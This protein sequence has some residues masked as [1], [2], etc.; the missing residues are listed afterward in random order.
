MLKLPLLVIAAAHLDACNGHS[1][2]GLGYHYH[3]N[4]AAKNAV[5]PCLAGQFVTTDVAPGGGPP[6]R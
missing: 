3:A 6:P 1:T 5:L 2:A 4:V